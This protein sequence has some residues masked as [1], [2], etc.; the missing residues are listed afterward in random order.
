MTL[1]NIPD[2]KERRKLASVDLLKVPIDRS[3]KK[4]IGAPLGIGTGCFCKYHGKILFLTAAHLY[5]NEEELPDDAWDWGFWAAFNFETYSSFIQTIP[6]KLLWRYLAFRGQKEEEIIKSLE[7]STSEE[8]LELFEKTE[9]EE[10]DFAFADVSLVD[11]SEYDTNKYID[12][13][14]IETDFSSILSREEEYG[15]CGFVK[16]NEKVDALVELPDGKKGYDKEHMQYHD[17]KLIEEDGLILKFSSPEN[18]TKE[19]VR[20]CSGAPI[21][22]SKG[23]LVALLIEHHE[24]KEKRFRPDG[25]YIGTKIKNII[26]G[27]NLTHPKI[28]QLVDLSLSSKA[29]FILVPS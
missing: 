22:D 15:F 19:Y 10:I 4:V 24:T 11:F 23:N 17:L 29:N 3:L 8:T 16:P 12:F 21:L 1:N 20:G 28:K 5:E 9:T 13:V 25:N 18:P 26:Y 14:S 2:I 27:V 7:Q 6:K